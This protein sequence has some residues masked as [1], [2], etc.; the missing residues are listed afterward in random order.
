M[1]LRSVLF[2]AYFAMAMNLSA[3]TN[4]SWWHA[5]GGRL[6]EVVNEMATNFNNSQSE[7]KITPIYK[8][9]Y[10]DT[11]TAGI[12]AFRA[13]KSPDIIQIFDAGAATM[14][15]AKG[16]VYP[17]ADLFDK[18]G[19]KFNAKDYISGVR[20]FYADSKGRMIGAPFN[21]STPIMYYNKDIFK[22]VGIKNP[23]KTWEEFEK[24]ASKLKKAGYIGLAQSHSPW[25]FAENFH[26]RHN[27]MLADKNNGF[28]GLATKI[29]YNNP[30]MV[31]HW[32]KVRSWI[33][34]GY[35]KYYGKGWSDNQQAFY[36]QKVAMWLG[37]SGSFG[38][39]KKGA[40]FEFGTTYLPYWNKFIDSGAQ[41]FIGGAA[42]FVFSGKDDEKYKGI[43]K[44]FQYLTSP[45]TQY[46]W[47]K[48]TGY[49]PVTNAA[50]E[51]AKQDG[52]Y[53]MAP[54][55]E[56]G[57]KQL[58]LKTRDWTKGY[59]L[60]NYVQIR[61]VMTVEFEHIYNG[62]KSSK[63]ALKAIETKANKLLEKFAKTYK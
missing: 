46:F 28:D 63:E 29:N 55:A 9:G 2:I 4:I 34:D 62:E 8:G 42:L 24:I 20:N 30:A 33:T 13:K 39:L 31:Y 45:K 61:E 25:I 60:G 18:Y 57:I 52:Y 40:K 11:M 35:Y 54:D 15:N 32:D 53:K 16:V 49:V 21:A 17:I 19:V 47:H 3:S 43:A 48:E 1:N 37:S 50:Y 36:D 22:K 51:M 7:Y 27:I 41:T 44:F 58:S 5:M 10:E 12:A 23:P 6:G 26:S 38:G 14:I 59:R 56:I